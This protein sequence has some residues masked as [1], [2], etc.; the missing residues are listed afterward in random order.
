[1][2]ELIKK[3]HEECRKAY[4][5][6]QDKTSA[7][8]LQLLGAMGAYEMLCPELKDTDEKLRKALIQRLE[9]SLKAAE[10]Q[11][12]AG[13]DRTESIEAYKWGLALLHKMKKGE[14]KQPV[15]WKPT[16]AQMYALKQEVENKIYSGGDIDLSSLYHDLIKL[17]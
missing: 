16:A 8:A 4:E 5:S 9:Q 3:Q 7:A 10:E 11:D 17:L 1:M 14:N 2:K 6:L 13:C 15:Q 12:A